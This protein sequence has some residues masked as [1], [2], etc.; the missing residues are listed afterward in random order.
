MQE[1]VNLF[2]KNQQWIQE[3]YSKQK[4]KQILKHFFYL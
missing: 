1:I 2:V 4:K 3:N